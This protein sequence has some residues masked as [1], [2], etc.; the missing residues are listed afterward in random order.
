MNI[1]TS[2]SSTDCLFLPLPAANISK[3]IAASS[4]SAEDKA[5]VTHTSE[6]LDGVLA[7]NSGRLLIAVIKANDQR[8]LF[9]WRNICGDLFEQMQKYRI[10]NI[11]V[12]ASL[13]SAGQCAALTDGIILSDYKYKKNETE[14]KLNYSLTFLNSS[15]EQ[16]KQISQSKA[17]ANAANKARFIADSPANL[18]TPELIAEEAKKIA[19]KSGLKLTILDEAEMQKQQLGAL[20]A[21]SQGSAHEARLICLEYTHPEATKTIAMVGKG[22][23]FDAGGIN[24]KP[25]KG[26]FEMKYDKSGGAAVLNSMQAIADLQPKINVIGV[27]PSSENVTGANAFK[28]GDVITAYNGKTIEVIDTDA[29]GRLLLCDAL[30]W[31]VAKF[32]PDQIV[33]IATLTGAVINALGRGIASVAGNSDEVCKQL[34][35]AGAEVDERLWQMPICD[36]HEEL[37]KSDF[38]DLANMIDTREASLM[39]GTVF[40]KEFIGDTP[41]AAIDIG[42]TAWRHRGA[43]YIKGTGAS[44]FGCRLLSQWALNESL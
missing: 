31:T 16:Q 17:Q 2:D 3:S 22:L 41:W 18:M 33:N 25:S 27:I 42:G 23:T 21:V 9:P 24:L 13:L 5:L 11:A 26:M 37:L 34:I 36:V 10:E 32:K 38:A 12:E 39:N 30:A 19:E 15:E 20:L 14:S 7:L 43:S 1:H 44:G 35:T 4:L 8:P 40:L 6:N 29:E 28:P